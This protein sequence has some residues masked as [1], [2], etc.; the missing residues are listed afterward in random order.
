MDMTLYISNLI[1][2]IQNQTI[3]CLQQR[4]SNTYI[5]T[6]WWHVLIIFIIQKLD[7]GMVLRRW[8]YSPIS[9]EFISTLLLRFQI[10]RD[11]FVVQKRKNRELPLYEFA[12]PLQSF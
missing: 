2:S 8:T 12:G 6:C 5:I 7:I 1:Y 11:K 10:L 3:L 4:H 9:G